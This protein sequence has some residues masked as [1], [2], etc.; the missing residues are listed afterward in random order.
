MQLSN[1]LLNNYNADQEFISFYVR[2]DRAHYLNSNNFIIQKSIHKHLF[3][4]ISK[5]SIWHC[6]YQSSLY[7]AP[8]R[9]RKVLTVHD[10]NF[11]H[12]PGINK[13]KIK[14]KLK[15]LQQ[16]I[17]KY[18]HLV[19]I[20]EFVKND[21]LQHVKIINKPHSVIYNG[22][23]FHN[24]DAISDASIKIN[25]PFLFTIGEV[26]Q[27]KNFHVL[28]SLL[29]GN[30]LHLVI[31][32]I[33]NESYVAR[34]MKEAQRLKVSNRVIIRGPISEDDKMW[35][36]KHCTAFVFPSLA[37]GFGL[38]VIEAMSY[39]KPVFLS[40]VTSLPEIGGPHAYYFDSFE[41]KDMQECFLKG[42]A[43]YNLRQP[44][45]QIKQWAAK[46]NWN[47]A[48]RQYLEVYRTL[49]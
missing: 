43:D 45:G 33:L 19:F 42:M 20:S 29:S 47:D 48:A 13:D 49:Y 30:N 4:N 38:P 10:M 3:P 41:Q 31:A 34:I 24:T 25:E 12:E 36:M 8:G 39:G 21:V 5:Y 44:Q 22:C 26:N 35:Y 1:A 7:H 15:K 2:K 32:G 28:P 17:A 9:I 23:N 16:K 40:K 14:V 46:F 6:N 27:K 11:L 37:E 18:D